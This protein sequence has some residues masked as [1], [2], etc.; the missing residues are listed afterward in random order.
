MTNKKIYFISDA[1]LGARN[2]VNPRE[3]EQ[4]LVR[5]LEY[6]RGDAAAVYLMGDMLDFWFEYKKVVPK[7][8]V[9]FFGKLAELTDSGIEVHWFT[10]NHDIWIFD[11]LP[12]E[13]GII[14]HRKPE[15]SILMGKCFFLAH[16]DGL[17]DNSLAFRLIRKIFHNKI[18]QRLF[19]AIH[20]RWSIGFAHT[21]SAHSRGVVKHHWYFGEDK[22]F[23]IH[24]SKNYLTKRP[25]IQYF[26][27]GHRH[28]LVDFIIDSNS[29][30]II[31]GDWI[32]YFSYAVFDG[33]ELILKGFENTGELEVYGK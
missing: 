5:W 22:E 25:D 4:K 11:Y 18:C 8:F 7:G 29:R 21:W 3:Q 10:G 27:F 33:N 30:M 6:V 1:H 20:P 15:E 9:R 13:T 17:A 2:I 19:S 14:I 23:L 24:F 28:I 12:Q 31:L 32:T 16:G 26:I